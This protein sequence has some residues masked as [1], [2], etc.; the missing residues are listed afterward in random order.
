M[1]EKTNKK[2]RQRRTVE[3]EVLVQLPE[4]IAT[5][6]MLPAEIDTVPLEEETTKVIGEIVKAKN[7]EELKSYTDM[8]SLNMAKKNAL[9][10][11]KLQNLLDKVND[12]A[13]DRFT[14]H[15]D[16]FSNKEVL[17]YMKAVQDQITA[18]SKALETVG[19]KP[20]IQIN[21]QKNE[22][23][24]NMDSPMGTF[25]RESKNKVTDAVKALLSLATASDFDNDEKEL[26]NISSDDEEETVADEE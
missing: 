11:A 13:I 23:N 5:D 7:A 1:E 25:T 20:M 12:N 9:R 17:D 4:E 21:N 16:E 8:F 2:H 18:S 6:E 26:Y 19:D 3:P 22:V 10:I 15:P 24:I 14:N